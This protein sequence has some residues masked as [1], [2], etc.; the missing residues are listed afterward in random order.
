[1]MKIAQIGTY[2]P[3]VGG[4]SIHMK[5]LSERLYEDGNI[6]H[7]HDSRIRLE[8]N[9][10]LVEGIIYHKFPG[11]ASLLKCL[12][13][14]KYDIVHMHTG[15]WKLLFA[16]IL[17]GQ[18]FKRKNI[19]TLHSFRDDYRKCS[20]FKRLMIRTVLT[21]FD[22]VICVGPREMEK[23]LSISKS[24]KCVQLNSYIKALPVESAVM[25]EEVINLIKRESRLIIACASA[26]E[27]YNGV[28]LYGFDMALELSKYL[29][30]MNQEFFFLFIV[31]EITDRDYY[32]RIREQ[33]TGEDVRDVFCLYE[34]CLPFDHLLKHASLFV[35][36]T[37]SDSYG[38]SCAEALEAGVSCVA[39]DVTKRPDGCILFHS[40]EQDQ[41]NAVCLSLLRGDIKKQAISVNDTFTDVLKIYGS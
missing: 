33:A 27:K 1:M 9:P 22:K 20:F 40:R 39:S 30:L 34:G 21:S 4:R 24:A 11:A 23:S 15:T 32:M 35:R 13:K 19:L 36:P 16:Y 38:L 25:P 41:F 2:P 10:D 6:V 12:F 31:T 37:A 8:G 3:P 17:L 28:D 18:F 7:I 26:T 29:K 5:N 14:A